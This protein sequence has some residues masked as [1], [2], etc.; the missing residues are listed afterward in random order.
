MSKNIVKNLS[1]Q[2]S[3][4]TLASREQFHDHVKQSAKN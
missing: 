3:T 2:C 1:G 4:D